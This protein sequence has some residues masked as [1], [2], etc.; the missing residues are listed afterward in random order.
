MWRH[1]DKTTVLTDN[2][3]DLDYVF[4]VMNLVTKKQR[5]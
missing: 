2:V 3:A 1:A 5:K 4:N